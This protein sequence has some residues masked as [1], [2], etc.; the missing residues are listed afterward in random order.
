MENYTIEQMAECRWLYYFSEVNEKG[1]TLIIELTK[2]ENNGSSNSL[3]N[4]WFKKGYT[5]EILNYYWCIDTYVR[6][7]EGTCYGKY[8][9]SHKLDETGKRMVINFDW[10]FEATEEN[11]EK[12]L[13]EVY[14]L[15]STAKGE[16][17]TQIKNRKIREYAIKNNVEIYNT[18]PE[19]W[20][21][22]NGGFASPIG[23]IWISNN[24]S[25]MSKER[26]TAILMVS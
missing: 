10:M 25:F 7:T 17:A 8:N 4:L 26:K 14:K 24:K 20:K 18:I 13:N 22:F 11:K 6:D 9:P 16:T 2:C 3:P 12:L 23:T 1:E 19:G 15:F 21:E 5:K